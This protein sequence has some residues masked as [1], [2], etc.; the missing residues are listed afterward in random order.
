MPSETRNL[1]KQAKELAPKDRARL[2]LRLI[3]SLDP[4]TDEDA[5]EQWL[6]E[7]ERRLSD[8]DAGRTEARPVDEVISEIEQ[9]LG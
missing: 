8:Y 1:E 6:D 9:K 4:G 5:E 7:A 3:E 2:A